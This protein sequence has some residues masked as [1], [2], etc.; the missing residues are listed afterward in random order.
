MIA[1]GTRSAILGLLGGG[2]VW[3][4]VIAGRSGGTRDLP[5]GTGGGPRISRVVAGV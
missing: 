1:P 4:Q 5:A 3:A 2:R